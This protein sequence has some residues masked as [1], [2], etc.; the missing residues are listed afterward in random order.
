VITEVEKKIIK[1]GLQI[2]GCPEPVGA[3]VIAKG[4]GDLIFTSG[5]TAWI[6]GVL[7]YP[8]KVGTQITL[9]EAK[10]SAKISALRCISALNNIEDLDNL[11]IVKVLGFVNGAEGFGD[12]PEVLNGASDLIEKVFGIDGKHARCAI[13]VATLPDNASVELEMIAVK[14]EIMN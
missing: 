10:E 8:G 12:H 4:A 7:K 1:L 9:D 14:K 13:G 6:D 2:P 3:Y 11:R 5:Q